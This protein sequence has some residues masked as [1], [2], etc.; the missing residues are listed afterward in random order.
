MSAIAKELEFVRQ[1]HDG[2][3]RAEDVVEYAKNP[4]TALHSRFIWDDT[5]AARQYRLEQARRVIRVQVE[6]IEHETKFITV[7]NFVHLNGNGG[8]YSRDDVMSNAEKRKQLLDQALREAHSWRK[9]YENL[10]ELADVFEA[11]D[12]VQEKREK[13]MRLSA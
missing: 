10:N 11:I 6:S 12:A 2:V 13:R 1:K 7:R 3:L 9:R 4:E 8:Y 5:E